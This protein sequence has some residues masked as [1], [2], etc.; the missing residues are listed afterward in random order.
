MAKEGFDGEIWLS[1]F[2]CTPCD[3]TTSQSGYV[4]SGFARGD[5]QLK[6]GRNSTSKMVAH[7]G[8]KQWSVLIAK[9]PGQK[10]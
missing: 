8:P 5:T 6:I 10:V 9:I 1:I 7:Q 4:F 3:Q 2:F